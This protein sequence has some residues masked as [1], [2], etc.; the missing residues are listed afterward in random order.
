MPELATVTTAAILP[1]THGICLDLLRREMNKLTIVTEAA[2]PLGVHM[3]F[4]HVGKID[5]L[6]TLGDH[7]RLLRQWL[8]KMNLFT[9]S[10][11]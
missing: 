5:V 1:L 2:S 8:N 4:A 11:G 9:L 6:E 7:T 3:R 10:V